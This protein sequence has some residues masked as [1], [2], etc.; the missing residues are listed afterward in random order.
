MLTLV[1]TSLVSTIEL[2]ANTGSASSF[3]MRY[4]NGASYTQAGSVFTLSSAAKSTFVFRLVH[5]V[6]GT[7]DLWV[8]GTLSVT[9]SGL[10]AAVNNTAFM[11]LHSAFISPVAAAF[12][13]FSQAALAD[14][15]LRA[16]VFPEDVL[17]A[18]GTYNAGTGTIAGQSDIDLNTVYTLAA[19]GDKMTG[20]TAARTLPSGGF[21]RAVQVTGLE[22]VNSP[23][24]NSKK[25]LRIG[26]TDYFSS[27]VV[28]APTGGQEPRAAYWDT[29]P[30]TA[31]AWGITNYNSAEKGHQAVT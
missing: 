17:S 20:T 21:I 29:D 16:Y 15:D 26:G 14:F 8:N 12:T 27:N 19:N 9:V 3:Y 22:R 6:S 2:V 13:Y 18:F 5:G 4:W 30:S 7:F 10:N 11:R 25:M 31:A 24:A 28:P 23:I 1:N